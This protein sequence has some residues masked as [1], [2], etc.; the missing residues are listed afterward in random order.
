MTSKLNTT[1][2]LLTAFFSLF[3]SEHQIKIG[4]IS[5]IDSDWDLNGNTLFSRKKVDEITSDQKAV[6]LHFFTAQTC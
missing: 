1:I 3:A 2:I 5:F 4:D 6:V